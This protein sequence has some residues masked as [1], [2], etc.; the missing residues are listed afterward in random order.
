MFHGQTNE[1]PIPDSIQV[2]VPDVA[3]NVASMGR[4]LSIRFALHE[5]QP[6]LLGGK[7]R[8]EVRNQRSAR[9]VPRQR[10]Y[11]LDVQVLPPPGVFSNGKTAVGARVAPND[12][13]LVKGSRVEWAVRIWCSIPCVQL[14]FQFISGVAVWCPEAHAKTTVLTMVDMDTRYVGVLMV[15]GKSTDNFFEVD[16]LICGQSPR[17][18]ILEPI[19]SCRS[20]KV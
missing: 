2:D 12:E 6:H 9:T 1:A 3:R 15:S 17:T 11:S 7:W 19:K 20:S 5:S 13:Q 4:L 14:D 8:R 10:L 18:T 16:S